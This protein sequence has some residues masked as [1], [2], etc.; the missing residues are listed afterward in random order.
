MNRLTP[1][2]AL[3]LVAIVSA[4][5]PGLA[6]AEST[7]PMVSVLSPV[8]G[9]VL[10][11]TATVTVTPPSVPAGLTA[12]VASASQINLSWN[13]S[14]DP[15]SAVAGY[16][17]Y[18][19][20]TKVATS[21]TPSYSNTGLASATTYT[22]AVSANDVAGNVSAMSANV[23]ATTSTANVAVVYVNKDKPCPGI[24]NSA[25]PY[26]SIQNALDVALPGFDIRIRKASSPYNESDFASRSGTAANP[27]VLEADDPSHPPIISG[28]SASIRLKQVNY[29]TVQNLVFD[30]TGVSVPSTALDVRGDV[31]FTGGGSDVV[32]IK[33]LNNTFRNWGAS[34]PPPSSGYFQFTAISI[35]GGWAPTLVTSLTISGTLVQGNIFDGIRGLGMEVTSAKNTVIQSNEFKSLACSTQNAGN[36]ST[37]VITDGVH[38]ISG[39]AGWN[40]GTLYKNNS[41]HDFQSPSQCPFTHGFGGYTEMSAVHCDVDPNNGIMESNVVWN[42]DPTNAGQEAIA[43]FVEDGCHGWTVK[44]NVVHDVGDAAGRSQPNNAGSVNS[45]FNNTF[46]NIGVHGL[47]VGGYAVVEN[48]I[49]DNSGVAQIYVH[50]TTSNLTIDYN[51]Y[52]DNSG[53]TTVGGWNSW[54][55]A[56]FSSWKT[57]C[58]CDAHSLNLN[59][60]FVTASTP[61]LHLQ[62]SSPVIDKGLTIVIVP[63]DYDGISRPQGSGYDMGAYEYH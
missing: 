30:G 60:Q 35:Q 15:D 41:F 28:S 7:L 52:W 22:Y 49:I 9:S 48:N 3:L 27:I 31:W 25:S 1:A 16:N 5:Y 10:S 47:E 43:L 44:N 17:I 57:I 29:W 33:I 38:E 54:G 40:S 53:G 55:G 8:S 12:A 32:G 24:G 58:N 42:L 6:T 59:P 2:L 50:N 13:A 26:C 39:T 46:Y 4:L 14:T 34:N 20:C 11:D 61:N 23:S 19:N 62:S 37:A 63:N 21:A 45:W 51:D 18:R 56:S 36:G